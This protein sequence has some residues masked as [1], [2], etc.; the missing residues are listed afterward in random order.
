MIVNEISKVKKTTIVLIDVEERFLIGVEAK[1]INFTK[2]V[3]LPNKK[4]LT[5]ES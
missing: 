4:P 2:A 1:G 5:I 3:K